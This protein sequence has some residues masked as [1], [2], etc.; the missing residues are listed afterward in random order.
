MCKEVLETFQTDA[1]KGSGMLLEEEEKNPVLI[2]DEI[3]L[4][5]YLT[6]SRFNPIREWPKAIG[7]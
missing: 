6:V 2:N 4:C 7:R 1:F 5:E 3:D